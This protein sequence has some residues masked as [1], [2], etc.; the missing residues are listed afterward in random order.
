M[1]QYYS[2]VTSIA[3]RTDTPPPPFSSFADKLGYAGHVP[4]VGYFRQL[5]LQLH[6]NRREF[7]DAEIMK[8]PVH[9]LT[10]D[11]SFKL[12]GRHLNKINGQKF[13]NGGIVTG[14]TESKWRFSFLSN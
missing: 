9:T 2:F 4:S 8:M 6:D 14:L 11:A 1:I 5:I 3:R 13:L 7:Q 10:Y 12:D